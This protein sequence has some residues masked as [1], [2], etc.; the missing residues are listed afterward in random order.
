[1]AT[2]SF[3]AIALPLAMESAARR[4]ASRKFLGIGLFCKR[5]ESS[6]CIQRLNWRTFYSVVRVKGSVGAR[7]GGVEARG[8]LDLTFMSTTSG[9][10]RKI[11]LFAQ[12]LRIVLR[13]KVAILM[14]WI[15][16]KN[17]CLLKSTQ[18]VRVEVSTAVLWFC[19]S[20]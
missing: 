16:W 12:A 15:A 4:K 11:P 3:S 10:H 5:K 1:M 8:C 17:S 13:L 6:N 19:L 18:P 9:A 14:L 2:S 7:G 20:G